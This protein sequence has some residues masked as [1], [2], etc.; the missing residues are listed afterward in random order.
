MSKSSGKVDNEE[1]GEED[2]TKRGEEE[3]HEPVGGESEVEDAAEEVDGGVNNEGPKC[4]ENK[5]GCPKGEGEDEIGFES[6]RAFC[7][8][9]AQDESDGCKGKQCCLKHTERGSFCGGRSGKKSQV[10]GGKCEAELVES[11]KKKCLVSEC[12]QKQADPI[13]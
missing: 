13:T 10:F 3:F 1:E 11:E 4:E 8:G 7:D 5:K 6:M 9:D 2:D 12:E